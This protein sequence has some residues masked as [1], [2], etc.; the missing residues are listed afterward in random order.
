M[1]QAAFSDQGR[2]AA[3]S[4]RDGQMP[5]HSAPAAPCAE[6]RRPAAVRRRPV[7]LAGSASP[8]VPSRGLVGLAATMLVLAQAMLS[9]TAQVAARDGS[10]G[11]A[12]VLGADGAGAAGEFPGASSDAGP[13]TGAANL[14]APAASAVD[15]FQSQRLR[16][17][18]GDR[19]FFA[20]ASAEIG[21]RARIALA[22]QAGWLKSVDARVLIVGHADDGGPPGSDQALSERR[23]EVVRGRLIEEGLPA[24]RIE[25]VARGRDNRI[26]LCNSANCRAQNR[27]VVLMVLKRD[28]SRGS[29]RGGR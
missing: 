5:E 4:E 17:E 24:D 13:E 16:L 25:V 8:A 27:R 6:A 20:P 14:P 2:R 11:I 19:V 26:A 22:R 7:R 18:V 28:S 15:D 3:A 21:L 1:S 23:A 10:D 12:R 29:G 9:S